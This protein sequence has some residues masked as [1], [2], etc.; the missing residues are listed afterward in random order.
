[1]SYW[2]TMSVWEEKK[3][4]NLSTL[5]EAIYIHHMET[6]TENITTEGRF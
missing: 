5:L 6:S 1:M 3:K 2:G 4:N